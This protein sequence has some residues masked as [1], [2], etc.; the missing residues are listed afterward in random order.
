MELDQRDTEEGSDGEQKKDERMRTE[1]RL[2]RDDR[3]RHVGSAENARCRQREREAAERHDRARD[4]FRTLAKYRRGERAGHAHAMPPSGAQPPNAKRDVARVVE[5][6]KERRNEHRARAESVG[7]QRD[8]HREGKP[9]C[10]HQAITDAA[11]WAAQR[12]AKP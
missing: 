4:I 8:E 9:P 12:N 10:P 5:Y 3:D 2:A 6:E 11:E 7:E 1:Y